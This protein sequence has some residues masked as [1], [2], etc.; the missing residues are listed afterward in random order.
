MKLSATIITL[1]E[2]RNIERCIL[3]LKNVADEIIVLDSNSTDQTEAICLA[4]NVTFIKRDWEGYSA[5]K[6]YLNSLAN[7]DFILSM[8]ADEAIDSEL[9]QEILRIKR[10][11]SN[12]LY[13]VNRMT[14]YCGKWI[15]HS[16]WYPDVKTRIFPK[17]GC[18]WDGE[19]VHEELVYPQGSNIVQLKG[20]LSHYSYYSYKDHRERADKYSTL[21][22]KKMNKAGKKASVLKPYLSGIAR[23]ISMYFI[24]AGFLDGK[25]GFKIAQISAQSNVFK[26][27]ELRRFNQG[28]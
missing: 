28:K 3:S 11:D 12:D 19:F 14:N 16:G 18:Y 15:K 6:N 1:N 9:E 21:T 10:L 24:K 2:E 7:F 17:E 25:M 20:H 13:S 23:F 8:D 4:H 5:S 27:Q 26:Y 22:A